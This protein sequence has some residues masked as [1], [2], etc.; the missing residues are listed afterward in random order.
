MGRLSSMRAAGEGSVPPARRPWP[1]P[2]SPCLR[3]YAWHNASSSL[4]ADLRLD[5]DGQNA[6][7][8]TFT[9]DNGKITGRVTIGA[10]LP[11]A[12]KPEEKLEAAKRKI[13]ALAAE[14]TTAA[15][16]D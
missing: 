16:K 10:G 4:M 6:F 2:S 9:G 7:K 11:D 13:R 12:R 5:Q 1:R 8:F 15:S 14:F 3:L